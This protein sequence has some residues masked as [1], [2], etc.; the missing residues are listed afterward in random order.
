[1]EDIQIDVDEA[2]RVALQRQPLLAGVPHRARDPRLQRALHQEPDPSAARPRR[3]VRAGRHR[4][5]S[6][7]PRRFRRVYRAASF[8]ADSGTLSTRSSAGTTGI[9]ASGSTCPI[10]SERPQRRPSTPR[11]RFRP[12]SSAR[13][14]TR[15]RSWSRSPSGRR[16]GPSTPA[17]S[18]STPRGS[19]ASSRRS[20]SRRNRRN[21]KWACRQASSSCRR[22]AI[23]R[24]PPP[25]SSGAHRLQQGHRRFRAGAGNDPRS[26]ERFRA[27]SH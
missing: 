11:P 4:R 20:G 18:V 22:S 5:R 24:R 26:R 21:S 14:S 16:R 12:A 17:A 19:R 2:I 9:G 8:P 7:H 15:T 13:R 6:N 23:W 27:L 1:M 10:R 3:L 25:M